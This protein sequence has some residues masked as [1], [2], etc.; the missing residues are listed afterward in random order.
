MLLLNSVL[1]AT[2]FGKTSEVALKYGRNLAR[3]FGGNLHV[4]HVAENMIAAAAAEFYPAPDQVDN[5]SRN[6]VDTLLTDEDRTV[7]HAKAVLRSSA[8]VAETIVKYAKDAHI[9]LI[10]VGTHGRAAVSHLFMGS[11]AEQVVR[12]APCP[13]L[14]VRSNERDFV[15]SDPVATR[16]GSESPEDRQIPVIP[17]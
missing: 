12:T 10:V 16:H 6:R 8:A 15:V 11:V 7:L 3:A 14:V 5:P 1:V 9:D 13:V 4:L 2:D 17:S